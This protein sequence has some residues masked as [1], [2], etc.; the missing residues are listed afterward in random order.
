[1]MTI[2]SAIKACVLRVCENRKLPDI[3]RLYPPSENIP[4]RRD[5]KFGVISLTDGSCGFFFAGFGNTQSQLQQ[6]NSQ[7]QLNAPT[8]SYLNWCN[9]ND[10]FEAAIGFGVLNAVSQHLLKAAHY[11]LDQAS[12]PVGQLNLTSG[13]HVGMVGFF[14]PLVKAL[15]EQKIRLTIIEKDKK[16]LDRSGPFEITSDINRINKCDQVLI[17]GSTLINHTLDE[18][19]ENCSRDA[20]TALIGPTASCLPDPLFER[21]IDVIG[22]TT[23]TDSRLLAELLET[24]EPW[25]DATSK[26]CISRENYPGI[27]NLLTLT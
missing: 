2:H 8:I 4:H 18:V 6:F 12:D 21:G 5:K 15:T 27:E 9:S 23:V 22:S 20:Q 10:P 11:Q 19:M 16:F 26:Y 7:K 3:A 1:M 13:Q 14:P 25:G 17:T 24:G